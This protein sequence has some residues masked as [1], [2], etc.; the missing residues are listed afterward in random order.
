[1][2]TATGDF[3]LFRQIRLCHKLLGNLMERPRMNLALDAK[4]RRLITDRVKSGKYATPEAVV[5][6]ALH[7]PENNEHADDFAPDEWDMLLAESEASGE[8]LDGEAVF[9]ELARLRTSR[10]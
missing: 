4:A 6:A 9:A 7:A 5:T 8:S 1:V 2:L 10:R 3:P